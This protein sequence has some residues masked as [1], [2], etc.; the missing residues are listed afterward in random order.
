MQFKRNSTNILC[1]LLAMGNILIF[2]LLLMT[3]CATTDGSKARKLN[4]QQQKA[5]Q[6]SLTKALEYEMLKLLSFGNENVKHE[7][8]ND[9]LPHF[10]KV[11]E[12][13]T[14]N[15]HP[16]IYQSIGNCYIKLGKPDSVEITYRLGTKKYPATPHYHRMLGWVLSAK[17]EN[18]EAVQEYQKAIELDSVTHADD[19][20]APGSI[21]IKQNKHKEA[22]PYFEKLAELEPKNTDVLMILAQIYEAL[23][24]QDAMLQAHERALAI[25]PDNTQL[26]F[27]IGE[28][29]YKQEKYE[30]A[31]EKF[32]Q[33]IRLNPE[34]LLALEILG[35]A[36]Q[37]SG[38][39]KKE[40]STYEKVLSLKPDHTK[41]LC[42]MA[43]SYKEINNFIKAYSF[44][45][46]ATGIDPNY[47]YAHFVI[48]EIFEKA[49]YNCQNSRDRE[50]IKFDD[51]LVYKMA[52]D[53][54]EIAKKDLQYAKRAL[55]RMNH[56]APDLPTKADRHMHPDQ[57]HPRISCYDW[58]NK[59]VPNPNKKFN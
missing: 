1:C 55:E 50:K 51:K 15:R 2:I 18:E 46:K 21:L 17:E 24:D 10:W 43:A 36:Y 57:K 5:Y 6:D 28:A 59:Y 58:I 13:D 37:N 38:D 23:G 41:V 3:G 42:E 47:G 22:I 39:F 44:A 7:M 54:Y 49:A 26:L 48:G 14:I 32:E 45:R 56:V 31:I 11:S 52:F 27:N 16:F 12:I 20:R 30:K 29:Y 53:E 8:Y 33:L 9:A 34:D 40:I 19:Y 25:A 35:Y 4:A